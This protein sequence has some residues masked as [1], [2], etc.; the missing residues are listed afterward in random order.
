MEYEP[1]PNEFHL[2]QVNESNENEVLIEENSFFPHLL[3][4]EFIIILMA[5]GGW[6]IRKRTY[7]M[8]MLFMHLF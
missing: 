8:G 5:Y 1:K 7:L 3:E 4:K 2:I 6:M